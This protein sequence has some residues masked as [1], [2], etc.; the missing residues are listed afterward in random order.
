MVWPEDSPHQPPY[1]YRVLA[2]P[3]PISTGSRAR[4]Q[5]EAPG[6]NETNVQFKSK[7]QLLNIATTAC[8]FLH[9][10]EDR[11]KINS[12]E[13]PKETKTPACKDRL[14]TCLLE[15]K[16]LAASLTTFPLQVFSSSLH[17]TV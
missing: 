16:T 6:L 15:G 9:R 12:S 11:K 1:L 10:L 14:H 5:K 7:K 17:P 4:L 2:R 13:H 3:V 8:T